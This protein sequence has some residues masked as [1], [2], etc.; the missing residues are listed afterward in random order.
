MRTAV[1]LLIQKKDKDAA[2]W[3][4]YHPISVLPVDFKIISKWIAHRLEDLMPQ[5][6]N[7][8]QSGFV[9]AWNASDN[10]QRFINIIDHSALYD[11]PALVISL[12]A[13]KAFDRVEWPYL[14]SVLKKF[15]VGDRCIGWIKSM[16]TVVTHKHTY[17]K[18][19][20]CLINLAYIGVV[21][22][23]APCSHSC[24]I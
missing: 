24:L 23:D 22:R 10:V 3:T 14:F 16:Y 9:K 1:I 6:I 20:L 2:E 4:S 12:D 21:G 15:N 5:L 8:D 18:M 13:E 7:P 19:W 17:V 11:R